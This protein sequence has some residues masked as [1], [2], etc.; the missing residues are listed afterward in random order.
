MGCH[1]VCADR[2]ERGW[3][4]SRWGKKGGGGLRSAESALEV[5]FGVSCWMWGESIDDNGRI[6]GC[7]CHCGLTEVLPDSLIF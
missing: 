3:K 4:K 1:A 7:F 6:S 5:L 2:G